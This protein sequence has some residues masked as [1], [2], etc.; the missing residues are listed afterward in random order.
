MIF[1]VCFREIGVCYRCTAKYAKSR[2]GVFP[3]SHPP[4]FSLTC[5]NIFYLF[6]F[7]YIVFSSLVSFILYSSVLHDFTLNICLEYIAMKPFFLSISKILFYIFR[8]NDG[9]YFFII[10]RHHTWHFME[11]LSQHVDQCDR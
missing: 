7:F 2:T 4:K 11:S 6:S 10:S 9:V 1:S 3:L 5:Y 8:K